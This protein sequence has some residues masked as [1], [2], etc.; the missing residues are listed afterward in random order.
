MLERLTLVYS[1]AAERICNGPP[2][3]YPRVTDICSRLYPAAELEGGC[4]VCRGQGRWVIGL[5]CASAFVPL[6]VVCF[7]F[8]VGGSSPATLPQRGPDDHCK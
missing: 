8:G 3:T 4:G 2:K 7:C 1:D 6:T 5:A